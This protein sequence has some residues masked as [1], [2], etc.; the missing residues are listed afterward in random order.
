MPERIAPLKIDASLKEAVSE[1]LLGQVYQRISGGGES[2]KVLFR[3]RPQDQLVS[4]F[5]LPPTREADLDETRR[6]IVISSHGIRLKLQKSVPGNLKLQIQVSA[7]VRML[8]KNEDLMRPGVRPVPVLSREAQNSMR[9]WVSSRLSTP[10]D[11]VNGI[12]REERA[13][14]LREIW[15]I[16]HGVPPALFP[17][18]SLSDLDPGPENESKQDEATA[19]GGQSGTTNLADTT[20]INALFDPLPVPHRWERVDLPFPELDLDLENIS[21]WPNITQAFS[22]T[23]KEQLAS[24]LVAWSQAPEQAGRVYR[25]GLKCK[26]ADLLDWSQF[27]E[28]TAQSD[29]PMVLPP[30]EPV[31]ICRVTDDWQVDGQTNLTLLV[32][33]RTRPPAQDIDAYDPALFGVSITVI[34][35]KNAH[36]PL[37]MSRVKRSYAVERFLNY[38]AMGFNG[39]VERLPANP[40]ELRLRT[41][42][43]PRFHQPRMR[44]RDHEGINRRFRHLAQADGHESLMPMVQAYVNWIREVDAEFSRSESQRNNANHQAELDAFERDRDLGWRRELDGIRDGLVILEISRKHWSGRGPQSDS[45]GAP[46]EAWLAMNEAMADM[47]KDK[48]KNDDGAWRLFQVAFILASLPSLVTRMSD[49]K[50]S[51]QRNRDEAVTLL[52]FST[53][54][55][56]SE[57]FLGLLLFNLFLD[58]LR[59]KAFGVT[60][61]MRY[62][63][64]LLTIQQAV[65]TAKAMAFAETIRIKREYSGEPFSIGFWV[66]STGTPNWHSDPKI[67]NIPYLEDV[68][69]ER[70]IPAGLKDNYKQAEVDWRK[71]THCP[72]C[73]SKTVLRRVRASG[74]TLA[75]V[76]TSKSCISHC[77]TPYKALPFYICDEDIYAF[78]PSVLLGTVDK[79]AL[80]GQSTRTIRHLFSMFGAAATRDS[81]T[82]RLAPPQIQNPG[83]QSAAGEDEN[84]PLAPAYPSGVPLFHDPFPSML[85]QDEAHLLD[86][87]LGT[88]A[89]L[90]ET[91]FEAMLDCLGSTRLASA[92]MAVAPDGLRRRAK[93]IAASATVSQPDRQMEHLYQRSTPTVLFPHPGPDIYRSFYAEPLLREDAVMPDIQDAQDLEEHRTS[94]SRIY[95]AFLTNGRP[96]TTTTVAIL[97]HFHRTIT[98]YYEGL[99]QGDLEEVRSLMRNSLDPESP[100][101]LYFDAQLAEAN[102]SQLLTLV[103]LHRIALTYVTNKKGGDQVQAAEWPEAKRIHAYEKSDYSPMPTRLITSEVEQGEIQSIIEDAQRR[104]D[105]GQEFPPIVDQM[106]SIIATSAVSHGVDVDE[107]NSMFFA[108]MPSDIAEYIQASSR[109]GRTHTGFCVLIPTPQQRRDRYVVEVFDGFHRFLE[110]MVQPAAIDRWAEQ[111]IVRSLPSMVMGYLAGVRPM[112]NFLNLDD[113]KDGWQSDRLVSSILQAYKRQPVTFRSDMV[114][115]LSEAIGLDNGFEPAAEP[116]YRAMIRETVDELI[117][118][119]QMEHHCPNSFESY[120]ATCPLGHAPMTSLR[121]VDTGGVIVKAN[122]DYKDQSLKDADV[123]ALMDLIRKGL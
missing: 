24:E 27:L 45:R 103:D 123:R 69:V 64:R 49:F 17:H 119:M 93:V 1:A 80:I 58:R 99:R 13:L 2:G 62:P 8:P 72:F 30:L 110:R 22:V 32:E 86:E 84:Y 107:F 4:G 101:G 5:L 11:D 63:L 3:V 85:I 74:G 76:C 112:M 92:G 25:K 75:H 122:H 67:Q 109:V 118:G 102:A 71:L 79:L 113:D 68:G 35:P 43:A 18:V 16:E 36:L 42:W 26:V 115:F 54:G 90:F 81:S 56:K 21:T 31:L 10:P 52:Y 96:H 98:L 117:N 53:G 120:M 47:M 50:H 114:N 34:L 12:S 89:G 51:F 46:Y 44:A 57:A 41:T 33:N 48:L 91:L 70:P 65:R 23:L 66:G 19:M 87:S 111:A 94:W 116:H 88:F 39:G 61:M 106:R 83:P 100:N 20:Q 15:L 14:K 78:A 28:R 55:G 40:G 77:G 37:P 97:G 9:E 73:S 82:G 60:A 104:V 105:T 38:P 29:D 7:Y 59:G 108:G 95:I 6:N 121:D